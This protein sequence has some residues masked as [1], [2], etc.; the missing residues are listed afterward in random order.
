M[1]RRFDEVRREGE[2]KGEGAQD[3]LC[4]TKVSGLL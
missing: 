2:R 3:R 4:H 1:L